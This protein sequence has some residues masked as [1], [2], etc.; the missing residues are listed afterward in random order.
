MALMT[1]QK[2]F[3]ADVKFLV[4]S[5]HVHNISLL[6]YRLSFIMYEGL[7]FFYADG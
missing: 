1:M 2:M 7:P 3:L 6:C 5:M 4:F